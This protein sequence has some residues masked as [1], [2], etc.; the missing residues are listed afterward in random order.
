MSKQKSQGITDSHSGVQQ[1]LEMFTA[2]CR[3]RA[4]A[5]DAVQ[6]PI[7][8]RH[9]GGVLRLARAVRE[10]V[11]RFT[12]VADC[13][14]EVGRKSFVRNGVIY[15][16]YGNTSGGCNSISQKDLPYPPM[17]KTHLFLPKLSTKR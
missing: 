5:I 9:A 7:S 2:C 12:H 17:Y 16:R 10:L 14:V 11:P 6:L 13:G 1:E 3:I 8:R 15:H 4:S